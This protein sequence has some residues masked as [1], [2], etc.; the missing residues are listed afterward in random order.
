MAKKGG[1][2]GIEFHE[3]EIRLVEM[4]HA[5]PRSTVSALG[6]IYLPEGIIRAGVIADVPGLTRSL[7]QLISDVGMTASEAIIAAPAPTVIV[8]PLNLPPAPDAELASLV[9]GE[10]EHFRIF[11]QG[12]AGYGFFKVLPAKMGDAQSTS[13]IL[14][15]SSRPHVG[16]FAAVVLDAGLK[17]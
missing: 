1:V 3:T 7:R 6:S 2:I 12:A 9:S 13:I 8:R 17:V 11:D 10:V 14:M 16:P 4:Q 5:G 15:G